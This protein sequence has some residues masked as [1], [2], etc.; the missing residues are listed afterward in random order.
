MPKFVW[1]SHLHISHSEVP[2]RKVAP[3]GLNPNV[4]NKYEVLN[5]DGMAIKA[6]VVIAVYGED[7]YAEFQGD[8]DN[9]D[10]IPNGFDVKRIN[11]NTTTQ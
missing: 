5:Q 7:P 9:L 3:N 11:N 10:F 1:G 8:R 4:H 2:G 6:D